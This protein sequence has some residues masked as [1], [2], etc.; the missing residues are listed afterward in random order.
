M[1]RVVLIGAP[2]SGKSKVGKA[3]AK[4]LDLQSED[5]DLLVQT[6][7]GMKISDIFVEHGEEVF[8]NLEF[9]ALVSALSAPS[10]VLS[11][12]GGA[13]IAE[14]AQQA[15]LDSGAPIIFLDVSLSVAAST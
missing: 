11:L 7:T 15:L 3:L 6:R 2:G 8:R 4:C 10:T 9:E 14:R 5:T 12:G 13:P 1:P